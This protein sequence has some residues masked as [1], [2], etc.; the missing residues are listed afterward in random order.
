MAMIQSTI[1]RLLL[2][3]ALTSSQIL[4]G[5]SCCCL[6]KIS[7]DANRSIVSSH[8]DFAPSIP[9]ATNSSNK[10]RCPKCSPSALSRLKATENQ[11]ENSREIWISQDDENQCRCIK[12]AFHATLDSRVFEFDSPDSTWM[13]RNFICDLSILTSD[14]ATPVL[15]PTR[16][17]PRL[18]WQAIACIWLN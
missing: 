3:L 5:L 7:C 14:N 6:G 10:P 15:C 2:L 11:P 4:S 17:L 9:I 18:K 1:L 8:Q 16:Q 13:A 12:S